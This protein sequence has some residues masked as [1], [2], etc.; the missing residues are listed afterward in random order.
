MSVKRKTFNSILLA[1]F[2]LPA[3]QSVLANEVKIVSAEFQQ[4]RN[5]TWSVNVG[6]LHEDS[7]WHHYAD[8][9]RV[10]DEQGNVLGERVLLHPHENEQPFVRGTDGVE[11]PRGS[12]IYIEAHDRVHGWT[13]DRL[14][15]DLDK[16][17]NGRLTVTNP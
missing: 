15:I 1:L 6:L 16:V 5:G 12:V 11:I 4:A 8:I 17:E 9:W 14:E 7:G 2:I 13:E 10:V 3:F